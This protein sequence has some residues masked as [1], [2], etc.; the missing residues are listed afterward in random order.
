LNQYL[1][2]LNN[3]YTFN[4]NGKGYDNFVIL[5]E[6]GENSVSENDTFRPIG[7]SNDFNS[8]NFRR[9]YTILSTD[10]TDNKK[11]ETFK[12]EMIGNILSNTSLINGDKENFEKEFDAYWLGRAKPSFETQNKAALE[13]LNYMETNVLQNFINFVAVDKTKVREMGYTNVPGNT[14]EDNKMSDRKKLINSLI[15]PGTNTNNQTFNDTQGQIVITKTKF[16]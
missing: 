2:R 14:T 15:L 10:V 13:F 1:A 5:P 16:N 9:E 6:T 11:Y 7:T 8:Q 4:Y 3:K 12:N